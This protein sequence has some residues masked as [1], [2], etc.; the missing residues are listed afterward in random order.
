M[1]YDP[2]RHRHRSIRLPGYDYAQ[3]GA[4]FLTICT[5]ERSPLF[6]Q[7]VRGEMRFN[8]YGRIVLACWTE[9]RSHYPRVRLDEFVVIPNHVHGIILLEDIDLGRAGFKPVPTKAT[10]HTKHH[11]LPEVVRGFKAFV[12]RRLKRTPQRTWNPSG[13][14]TTTNASSETKES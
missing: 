11:A 13:N 3:A 9:L 2:D 10:S 6:G 5:Q 8:E 14:E 1:R 12:S 7:V 4:Y